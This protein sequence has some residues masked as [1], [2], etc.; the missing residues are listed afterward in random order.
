VTGLV[1]VVIGRKRAIAHGQIEMRVRVHTAAREKCHLSL[2]ASMVS[3]RT[4]C[5]FLPTR[6]IDIQASCDQNIGLDKFRMQP[7][8]V[9]RS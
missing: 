9:F 6:N 7:D 1:L 5:K 2:D 8:G 4:F 3:H